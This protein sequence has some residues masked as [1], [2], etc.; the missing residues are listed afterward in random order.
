MDSIEILGS[1]VDDVTYADLI[2]Q[3]DVFVESGKP[4]HIITVNV[5]MLVAAHDDPAFAAVL[6]GGD[7]NVADSAGLMLAARLLGCPLRERVTGSD[8]IHRLATHSGAC[9]CVKRPWSW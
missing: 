8:G 6:S 5:E 1:R 9:D 2:D 3:V 4:H 7:L